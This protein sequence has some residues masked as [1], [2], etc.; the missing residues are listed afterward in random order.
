MTVKLPLL[1]ERIYAPYK[2]AALVETLCD[3][4]ISPEECLMGSGI[5]EAEIYDPETLTS[6]R[7]YFAVCKNAVHLSRDP[8]T[9]FYVGMRMHLSAYGMYGYALICSLTV[10]DFF[11]L[12]VKYH[13]LAT[14]TLTIQWRE[15]PGSAIWR[16]PE[17]FISAPSKELR[18]F[19]IEQQ[20]AQHVTHLRDIVSRECVPQK[21][22]VSYPAPPHAD[23]YEK[24][25]SCPVYFNQP[26]S[27]IYYDS[28]ILDRKPQLAHRLTSTLLQ[29]TCDRLIGQA[30]VS[31]GVAGEVY[32]IL[33][34][35]PG[36]FPGMDEVADALHMTSRTLRRKLEAED[37]SFVEIFNDVRCSLATEY[38]QTTKLS[39]DDIATLLGF[40]DAANFRH[41]FK[42]WTGKAPSAYRK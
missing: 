36:Q 17:N 40:S 12:G 2:I 18:Q 5:T 20:L 13:K 24:F 38:L 30:K 39:T 16:F 3:Q 25:L 32:Q 22:H 1:N 42:K 33:M 9:P 21:I 4:G 29:E 35:T 41:A 31:V 7:Q 19:L 6:V 37:I 23:L 26:V 28:A 15:D 34:R 8:A 27:E 14:P 10:R 11:D